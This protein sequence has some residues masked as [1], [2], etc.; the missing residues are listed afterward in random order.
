MRMNLYYDVKKRN[1][2]CFKFI[3]FDFHI[4]FQLLNSGAKIILI[5]AGSRSTEFK[6]IFDKRDLF[7]KS[8]KNE[9]QLEQKQMI[10][11]LV[12]L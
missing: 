2:Q 3:V 9:Q 7:L 5:W 4:G 10:Y 1:L 11:F 12:D 8:K 6:F